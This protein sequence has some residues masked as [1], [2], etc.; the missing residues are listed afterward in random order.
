MLLSSNNNRQ[1]S[2]V[3]E[4]LTKLKVAMFPFFLQ[5]IN[6]HEL[7]FCEGGTDTEGRGGR[8]A[9]YKLNFQMGGGLI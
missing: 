6:C 4:Y 1:V 9:C 8:G 5:F 3:G 2:A 7:P